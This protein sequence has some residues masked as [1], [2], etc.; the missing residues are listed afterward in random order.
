MKTPD[1]QHAPTGDGSADVKGVPLCTGDGGIGSPLP[2]FCDVDVDMDMCYGNNPYVQLDDS[3]LP[4][5]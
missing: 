2:S 4:F 5:N 1:L 3:S